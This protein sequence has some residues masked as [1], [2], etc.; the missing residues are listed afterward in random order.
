MV[1]FIPT[2]WARANFRV[3]LRFEMCTANLKSGHVSV[4]AD[5]SS[6][7][8]LLRKSMS[9]QREILIWSNKLLERGKQ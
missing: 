9:V 4:K 3:K 6:V 2:Y 8:K 5:I 7:L 1:P